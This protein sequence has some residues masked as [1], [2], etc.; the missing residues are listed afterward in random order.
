MNTISKLSKT[1]G[2]NSDV[3]TEAADLNKRT[4]WFAKNKVRERIN[5]KGNVGE[6]K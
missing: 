3:E 1:Y 6:T 2:K 5:N 4:L